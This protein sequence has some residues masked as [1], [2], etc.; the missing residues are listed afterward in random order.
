MAFLII[1]GMVYLALCAV[2]FAAQRSLIYP[3]PHS[4]PERLRGQPGFGV[5]PLAD[6]LNVD[7]F[8]LPAPPGAPTVVHFHGNGEQLLGQRGFG[9]ALGDV[10]L[11]FLAVEYP[12]YGA[13]P[14]SPTEAGL[15]ASA[16][17]ALQ[18]LRDQGVKPEDIVL[19]GRS[20]GTGVAVEMARRGYGAR[21]V[22]VSPYTSMVAMGQR[23]MPF[24][25]ASLLMRDRFLSLDKAPNIPIPVL[26][27]HGEEDEVVPVDMGRTL[28]QRLP[29]ARVVTVPGAHH[30]DVLERDG[31][32]EL[33]RLATF[34]LDGS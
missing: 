15:Y 23:T 26:I 5:V 11:G 16:E 4:E 29:N 12:G 18:F 6:G 20:L 34:A 32:Q 3:A 7:R 25:P 28:G 33:A 21:M 27:I 14:G 10:G 19:S 22:L 2:L 30:N 1:V 13:S 8:Y 9:Q 17:A 24:L 31:Q